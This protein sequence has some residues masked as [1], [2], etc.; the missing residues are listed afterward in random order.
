MPP[1]WDHPAFIDTVA[2]RVRQAL[3]ALPGAQVVYTA[4]SVPE[5][6]ARSGP[7]EQQLRSASSMVNERL[8]L[9]AP[10]LVFQSRSGPLS[11]PWLG[12]DIGDYIRQTESRR[13][14]VAPIGFL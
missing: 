3:A 11:Q 4:H 12:P 10:L 1:F 13:L 7:Y 5:A 9:G 8:G 2:D 6:M 14:I